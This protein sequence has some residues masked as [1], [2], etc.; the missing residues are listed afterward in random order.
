[1]NALSVTRMV[2]IQK[3][4]LILKFLKNSKDILLETA[5]INK[6]EVVVEVM[7]EVEIVEIKDVSIVENQAI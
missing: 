4:V 5:Q 1:M 6:K 7:A 3:L 2:T